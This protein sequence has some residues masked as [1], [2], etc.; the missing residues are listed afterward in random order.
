ML[1]NPSLMDRE[2]LELVTGSENFLLKS[3]ITIKKQNEQK[4]LKKAKDEEKKRELLKN[5]L[6][7]IDLSKA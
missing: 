6:Q 1:Q 7:T 2:F 5:K 3:Q 4:E